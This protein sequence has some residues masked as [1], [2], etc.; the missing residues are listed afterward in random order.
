MYTH[1]VVD[2]LKNWLVNANHPGITRVRTCEEVGWSEQP[3]GVM[4]DLSDGWRFVLQC[5]GVA[6]DGGN[7]NRDPSYPPPDLPDVMWDE[8]PTYRANRK[9]F[10]DEVRGQAGS[11]SRKPQASP[12]ALMTVALD[13][14]KKAGHDGIASVDIRDDRPT[15][16]VTCTDGSKVYCMAA[17][18]IAPGESKLAHPAH[19]IPADWSKEPARVS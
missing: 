11:N 15:V 18:Y 13:L 3:V 8:M 1:H 6:P 4:I 7:V 2:E 10:E 5:V 9:K 19:A 12:R 14:I 16:R 17:G